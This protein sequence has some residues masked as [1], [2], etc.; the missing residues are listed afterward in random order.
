[1]EKGLFMSRISVRIAMAIAVW[2]VA[3]LVLWTT[4]QAWD[5][6]WPYA[7]AWAR[8]AYVLTDKVVHSVGIPSDDQTRVSRSIGLLCVMALLV[9]PFAALCLVKRALVRILLGLVGVLLLAAYFAMVFVEYFWMRF[10]L[11]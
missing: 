6:G 7:S 1:M 2:C 8:P 10:H 5:P 4:T 11:G 3:S 9:L